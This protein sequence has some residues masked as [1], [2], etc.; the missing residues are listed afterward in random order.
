MSDDSAY[1]RAN[2][3][4]RNR[5]EA[6]KAGALPTVEN[7]F[8]GMPFFRESSELDYQAWSR[9]LVEELASVRDDG[10]FVRD[11]ERA[12]RKFNLANV[13]RVSKSAERLHEGPEVTQ[14]LM[15]YRC[16]LNV[17]EI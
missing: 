7:L 16:V 9:D 3:I 2:R 5:I 14:R 10:Q 17:T 11:I 1:S 8:D 13:Q 15:W 6:I 4:R 12:A